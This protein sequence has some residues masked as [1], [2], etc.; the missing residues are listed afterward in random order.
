MQ[1]KN[2]EEYMVQTKKKIISLLVAGTLL[3][4]TG[5]ATVFAEPGDGTGQSVVVSSGNTDTSTVSPQSQYSQPVYDNSSVYVPDSTPQYSTPDYSS[6]SYV[7][8]SQNN[9]NDN[10]NN[11]DTNTNS[12]G[13]PSTVFDGGNGSAVTGSEYNFGSSAAVD[14]DG[15]P[16][17]ATMP[18][19]FEQPTSD[20]NIY[21][22]AS[23]VDGSTLSSDEWKIAL[24]ADQM[25]ADGTGDFSFIKDNDAAG[26]QNGSIWFLVGG[27][28]C[29]VAAFAIVLFVILSYVRKRKAVAA[30]V[31]R[32]RPHR[33]SNNNVRIRTNFDK[34]KTGEIDIQSLQNR[35]NNRNNQNRR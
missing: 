16:Y 5:A 21:K 29:F 14:H 11:N 10:S 4:S 33:T 30:G 23:S 31:T 3:L 1:T 24:N 26:D 32:Q 27:I 2:L 25:S 22:V 18:T 9:N 20:P 35:Q 34:D 28:I 12:Q 6:S 13:G 19:N 15:N 8:E 17:G 7:D